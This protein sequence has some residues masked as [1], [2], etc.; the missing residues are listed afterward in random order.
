MTLHQVPSVERLSAVWA[1][2][3]GGGDIAGSVDSLDVD[4]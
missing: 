1:V 4:F 2:V 3:R